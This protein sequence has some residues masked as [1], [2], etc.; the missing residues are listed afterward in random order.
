MRKKRKQLLFVDLKIESLKYM[1]IDKDFYVL[2][3][4][5]LT[6][7]QLGK[8][9]AKIDEGFVLFQYIPFKK[10]MHRENQKKNGFSDN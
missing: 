7:V 5:R 4:E 3:N 10:D 1:I 2:K 8:K 6:V 9:V